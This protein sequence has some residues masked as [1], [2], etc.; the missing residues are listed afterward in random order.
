MSGSLQIGTL[1]G[2]VSPV[3]TNITAGNNQSYYMWLTPNLLYVYGSFSCGSPQAGFCVT[4]PNS[5][6]FNTGHSIDK[7]KA[8]P[9]GVG[10]TAVG[11]WYTVQ[12][13]AGT[14]M[15]TKSGVIY[16]DGSAANLNF[17][18]GGTAGSGWFN[19]TAY[20]ANNIFVSGDFVSYWY[21]V[22]ML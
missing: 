12:T 11:F 21:I 13:G 1:Q 7:T 4:A 15:G 17:T 20:N 3:F 16:C 8:A 10:A 22:P 6:G 9:G 14:A 19:G 5:G 18:S 2:P